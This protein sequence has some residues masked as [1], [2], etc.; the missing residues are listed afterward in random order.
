MSAI[1]PG[2]ARMPNYR[3][4]A[5]YLRCDT[6]YRSQSAKMQVHNRF[7]VDVMPRMP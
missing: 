1:L 2:S 7:K 5:M 4:N 6:A 3:Q